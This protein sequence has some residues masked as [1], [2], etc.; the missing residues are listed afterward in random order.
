M[1]L[2]KIKTWCVVRSRVQL[3]P[4]TTHYV[5]T[6]LPRPLKS[7]IVRVMPPAEAIGFLPQLALCDGAAVAAGKQ[8]LGGNIFIAGGEG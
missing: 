5:L 8:P 6:F 4:R 3:L 1:E 2:D 7:D